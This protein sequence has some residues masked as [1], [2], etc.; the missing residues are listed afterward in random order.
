MRF[1]MDFG[2]AR[3]IRMRI[4]NIKDE[5]FQIL[6]ANYE[7]TKDEK[8]LESGTADIIDH[9]IDVLV[10]PKERGPYIL[11]FIYRIGDEILIEKVEIVVM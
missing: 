8:L 1:V 10:T 11:K 9:I 2:E 3:H 7:L 4:I 6:S 5:P